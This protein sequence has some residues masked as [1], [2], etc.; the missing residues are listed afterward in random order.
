MKKTIFSVLASVM[1]CMALVACS[2]NAL[3]EGLA[4]ANKNM[5]MQVAQGLTVTKIVLENDCVVYKASV[6][7]NIFDID[8]MRQTQD[9]AREGIKNYLMTNSSVQPLLELCR[10]ENKG[11]AY[12]YIGNQTNKSLLI[13]FDAGTF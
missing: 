11:I 6:D 7:E 9:E 5:P 1:M 10:K 3:N 2:G 4:E 12:E 13:K 8:Q